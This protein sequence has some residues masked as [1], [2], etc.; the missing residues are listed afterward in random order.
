MNTSD[1]E[2]LMVTFVVLCG[3]FLIPIA[4]THARNCCKLSGF[5][6][7]QPGWACSRRN[8]HPLTPIMVINCPL[9]A[10]SI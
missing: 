1:V 7:G 9:S 6:P 8:N 10:S 5:C 2:K 3:T 4:H